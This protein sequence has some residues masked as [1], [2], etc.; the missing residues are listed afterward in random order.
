[1]RSS[2]PYT[3]DYELLQGIASGNADSFRVLFSRYRNK[4]YAFSLKITRSV[5]QAEEI[6]Q[7]VFLK[8]WLYREQ[9][10]EVENAEAWIIT[11]TKNLCFNQLKKTAGEKCIVELQR[12]IEEGMLVSIEQ[13][14]DDRDLLLK[15]RQAATQL[16]AKE[17]QVYRMNK[18]Q[19]LRNEEI[20][21]ALNISENTV[22][23]HLANALRKIRQLMDRYS[24]AG[25]FV[26]F[27]LKKLF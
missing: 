17:Q 9:M 13:R 5:Y 12:E 24:A 2:L 18:E 27:L 8:L 25:V 19:G 6:T 4:V 21:S 14:I 15:V 20:A 11:I 23:V 16:T 7:E 3:N 22:K 10:A 26:L 1:M